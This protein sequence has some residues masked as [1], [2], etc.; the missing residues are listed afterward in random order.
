MHNT[1][2]LM[3]DEYVISVEGAKE[4]AVKL[5]QISEFKTCFIRTCLGNDIDE[6]SY[7]M[8]VT[9]DE[10]DLLMKEIGTDY[11]LMTDCQKGQMSGLW[12]RLVVLGI[13]EVIEEINPG[14]LAKLL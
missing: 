2:N 11:S 1:S 7:K 10:I 12:T 5:A 4:N 3:I 6:L 9:L 14:M 13:L 8:V